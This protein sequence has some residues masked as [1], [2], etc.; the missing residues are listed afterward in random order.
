MVK[1]H[2]HNMKGENI[3]VEQL[4]DAINGQLENMKNNFT[5]CLWMHIHVLNHGCWQ[6]IF[7]IL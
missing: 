1:R 6:V 2:K 3:T 4:D 5:Y 7:Q